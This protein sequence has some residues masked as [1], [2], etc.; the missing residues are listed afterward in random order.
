MSRDLN[1][2]YRRTPAL[3]QLDT[4]PEGFRWIDANDAQGNVLSFLRY[5]ASAPASGASGVIAC[6]AN[7]SAT[8]HLEYR[9]GLPAAGRWREVIN[10]DAAVYGGSGVGNLGGI[11]AVPEPWHGLE[12]SAVISVP[13]LGVLWLTPEE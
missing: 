3:W 13:P 4:S 5:P 9:I 7:F 12:A 2:A 6:I 10:T 8:P 1:A 11:D